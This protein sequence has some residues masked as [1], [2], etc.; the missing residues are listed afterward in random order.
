MSSEADKGKQML[1]TIASGLISKAA[2]LMG[3]HA[4]LVVQ[5]EELRKHSEDLRRGGELINQLVM[6]Y[7]LKQNGG[8]RH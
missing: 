8:I 3:Q 6:Q 7:E 2:A 4:L 5:A 1:E